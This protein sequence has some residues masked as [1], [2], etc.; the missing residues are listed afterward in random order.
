MSIEEKLL[1]VFIIGCLFSLIPACF[2]YKK[3][4]GEKGRI[5]RKYFVAVI[6]ISLTPIVIVTWLVTKLPWWF[7]IMAIGG[8]VLGALFEYLFTFFPLMSKL[9]K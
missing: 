8:L 1:L 4:K 6:F 7:L 5:N 3:A 9:F 2:I